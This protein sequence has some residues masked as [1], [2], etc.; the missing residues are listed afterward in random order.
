MRTSEET[1][2]TRRH[3]GT[4]IHGPVK[5]QQQQGGAEAGGG[6]SG[7]AAIADPLQ[8]RS[9][10]ISTNCKRISMTLPLELSQSQLLDRPCIMGAVCNIFTTVE[11]GGSACL[12]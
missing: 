7:A 6:E 4:D 12:M 11:A 5:Q 9:H 10:Y 8:W 1:A 2:T 3:S